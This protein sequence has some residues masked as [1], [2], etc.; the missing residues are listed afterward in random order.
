MAVRNSAKPGDKSGNFSTVAEEVG[1]HAHYL[2][3]LVVKDLSEE[4]VEIIGRK[5]NVDAVEAR[6]VAERVTERLA[7]LV[8]TGHS[9]KDAIKDVELGKPRFMN[10]W[11][12]WDEAI[13]SKIVPTTTYEGIGT[14]PGTPV[15]EEYQELMEVITLVKE[16]TGPELFKEVLTKLK[17]ESVT[18]KAA[19]QDVQLSSKVGGLFAQLKEKGVAELNAEKP[20]AAESREQVGRKPTAGSWLS[21][22]VPQ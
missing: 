20:K 14:L 10:E 12:L 13:V 3:S 17:E 4:D 6:I 11:C 1:K 19:L 2:I 8:A 22:I 21:R 16:L 9:V 7:N 18:I 15:N 5:G